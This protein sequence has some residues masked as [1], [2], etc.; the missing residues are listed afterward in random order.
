MKAESGNS[1]KSKRS[2]KIQRVEDTAQ[3]TWTKGKNSSNIVA[4]VLS[5]YSDYS[6]ELRYIISDLPLTG[7]VIWTPSTRFACNT[8]WTCIGDL[9]PPPPPRCVRN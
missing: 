7:Y 5:G 8:Q 9:T 4:E 6:L 2:L 1:Q 3:V